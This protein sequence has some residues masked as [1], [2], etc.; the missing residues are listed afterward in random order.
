MLVAL[1]AH[2][3]SGDDTEILACGIDFYL[4]KPLR[5]AAIHQMIIDN[6][7]GPA[8]ALPPKTG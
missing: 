2:A 8:I 3:M 5:K 6:A 7:L 4:T 1:T